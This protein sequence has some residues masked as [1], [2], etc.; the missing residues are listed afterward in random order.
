MLKQLSEENFEAFY[1]ILENSFP[2]TERRTKAGQKALFSEPKY[3]IFGIFNADELAAFI[4]VWEFKEFAFVEHFAVASKHRNKGLGGS[5]LK[6]LSKY[7][8]RSGLMNQK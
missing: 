8:K 5:I 4:A 6:E 1:S 7:M 3:K 2:P